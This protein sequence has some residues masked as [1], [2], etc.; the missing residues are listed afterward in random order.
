MA[1]ISFIGINKAERCLEMNV[2]FWNVDSSSG[3]VLAYSVASPKL[4]S[5]HHIYVC[6]SV[7]PACRR[8]EAGGSEVQGCP[9][10]REFKAILNQLRLPQIATPAR[11][12]S[13]SSI[14]NTDLSQVCQRIR[15]CVLLLYRI[16]RTFVHVLT[17]AIR[18]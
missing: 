10:L 7:V 5:Q 18:L 12:D 14:Q 8:L 4:P 16:I 9:Q 13:I 15:F 17:P 3:R 1:K 6:P 2:S 11:R